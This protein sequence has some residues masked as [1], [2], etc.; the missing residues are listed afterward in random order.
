M[1]SGEIDLLEK[2]RTDFLRSRQQYIDGRVVDDGH[3]DEPFR[4]MNNRM[5][6]YKLHVRGR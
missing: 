3:V 4:G 6:F 2:G 1:M 5:L